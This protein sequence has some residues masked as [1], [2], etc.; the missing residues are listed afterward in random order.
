MEWTPR[1]QK[2][3]AIRG[4]WVLAIKPGQVSRI[5]IRREVSSMSLVLTV[6]LGEPILLETAD[7][8]IQVWV[9]RIQMTAGEGPR[10][11]AQLVFDAPKEVR[12]VRGKL[13]ARDR[14]SRS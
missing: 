10:A 14:R 9:S 4:R 1:W 13:L 6:G 12:I 2:Q 3:N 8:P 7:G 5:A 11:D